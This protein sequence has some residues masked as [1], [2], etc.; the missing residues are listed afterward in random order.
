M[1]P[2]QDS[3]AT[4]ASAAGSAA[5]SAPAAGSASA[6]APAPVTR[7]ADGWSDLDRAA[8]RGDAEAVRRLLEAGADPLAATPDGRT[9]YLIA[10]AAGHLDAARALREAEDVADPAVLRDRSWG[11]YCRAYPLSELS[12][13]AAWPQPASPVEALVYLHDDLTVTE[14]AWPGEGVLFGADLVSPEWEAFCRDQLGF[15]VPDDFDLAA[16]APAPASGGAG[17]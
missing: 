16:S 3:A 13:F 14:Q 8:G 6:S 11:P 2:Q 12:A 5:A 17:G 9:P 10:L 7:D 1:A 15:A 4:A